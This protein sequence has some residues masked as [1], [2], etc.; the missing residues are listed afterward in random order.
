MQKIV[1]YF[2]LLILSFCAGISGAF[3]FYKHTILPQWALNLQQNHQS[4]NYRTAALVNPVTPIGADFVSASNISRPCV[5]YIKV[6][7]TAPQGGSFGFWDFFG[8]IG[9]VSSSGSGVIISADGYIATNAHVVKDADKIEVVLNNNKRNFMAKVIGIDPSSDLAVLKIEAKDL[10]FMQFSNSDQLNIGQWVLA[11]GNPFNLTSTVTAGIVSAK[12]RNINLV[13]NQFPIESF[14]QTDAAINPG[15]SGG[16]LVN[17]DGK[18]VGI[19][20]AIFSKTG[21]Y[22]GYGF[23][24]PSNIVR[25]IVNDIKDFGYVQRAFI[26]AE[27]V[28]IDERIIQT[29]DDENINGVYTK[30]VVENG[31]AFDAGLR[32]GDIILQVDDKKVESRGEFDELLAYHRPGDKVKL[33]I[34][35]GK[36]AKEI[37]VTLTNQRGTTALEKGK[38]LKSDYLG[39]EFEEVTKLEKEKLGIANGARIFNIS[40]SGQIR[41]MSLPEGFII[42]AFNR[43]TFTT[44]PELIKSMENA[45]G[46]IRIDGVNPD[47]SRG[48]FSFYLY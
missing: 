22:T 38:S 47:G 18:L 33:V 17:T 36:E 4:N 32:K 28:D 2:L 48:S 27:V 14:I 26:E 39:A 15:N 20:T 34:K 43:K 16:A 29:I 23:A 1:K 7:S 40:S 8:N 31:N 42:T 19:N 12:G 6:Q 21:S 46:N 25:K 3:V 13:Q 10:P 45:N 30:F 41:K 9:P 24:I 37:S 35:R 44:I 5:V 11:V